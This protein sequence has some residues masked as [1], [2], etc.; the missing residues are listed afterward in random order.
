LK[1]KVVAKKSDGLKTKVYYLNQTEPKMQQLY[2]AIL[3]D[4]KIKILTTY[5]YETNQ[6]EEIT[7]LFPISFLQ[8]LTQQILLQLDN[9]FSEVNDI[10]KQEHSTNFIEHKLL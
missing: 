3:N 8:K 7:A 9:A 5:N 1:I 2:M 10:N 4:S 6:F